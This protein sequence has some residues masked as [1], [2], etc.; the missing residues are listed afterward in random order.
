VGFNFRAWNPG[1]K[2][3]DAGHRYHLVFDHVLRRGVTLGTN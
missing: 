2:S 3:R 1:P